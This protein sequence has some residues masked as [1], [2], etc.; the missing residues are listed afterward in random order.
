MG[1]CAPHFVQQR[2]DAHILGD[3]AWLADKRLKAIGAVLPC[4][5]DGKHILDMDQ[6]DH[7]VERVAV[8]WQPAVAMFGDDRDAIGKARSL[9]SR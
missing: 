4:R 3:E 1:A 8:N 6:A 2:K 7:A 5:E 9:D